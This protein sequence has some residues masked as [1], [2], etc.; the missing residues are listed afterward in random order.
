MPSLVSVRHLEVHRYD[1]NRISALTF[2][3]LPHTA[4]DWTMYPFSSQNA[5]D[6]QNLLSVY[7]DCVFFPRLRELDFRYLPH[8]DILILILIVTVILVLIL[9]VVI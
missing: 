4:N 1:R 3:F 9:I 8:S 5:K 6:F 2:Y 7:L